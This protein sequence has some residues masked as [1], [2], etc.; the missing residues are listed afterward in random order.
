MRVQRLVAS[1]AM[2]RAADVGDAVDRI[3]TMDEEFVASF[4]QRSYMHST[5]P[6]RSPHT[7]RAII[8]R[9]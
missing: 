4:A 1:R 5:T 8:Q 2:S 7:S 3:D 6:S 9:Y